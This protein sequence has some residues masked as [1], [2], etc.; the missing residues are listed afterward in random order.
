MTTSLAL[1]SI[2]AGMALLAAGGESLVRGAV[3][4]ARLLRV[5]TVVIGLTIVAMGTSAPELAASLTAALHGRGNIAVGNV[6]GSNIFN[7]ALIVGA[8][9]VVRPIAVHLSAVQ[10]EWP[11]MLTLSVA[12]VAM[13]WDGTV[14]RFEG[15]ALV[16]TLILFSVFLIVRA[17]GRTAPDEEQL[18][19][20]AVDAR[21]VRRARQRAVLDVGLVVL[22][23]LL[24]VGGAQLLIRGAVVVA[25]LLGLSDRVIGLTIVAAG[26]SMPEM[27]TSLVAARRGEAE[28]ALANVIGSNIF[29]I[30]G[31]L[32]T[33]ALVTPQHVPQATLSV[34]LWWMLGYTVVLLPLMRTGMRISRLEGAALLAGY[35]VY[36]A[37]LLG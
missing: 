33:V 15:A 31:I 25:E 7:I 6:V 19:T 5:G 21:T 32:G 36:L 23:M 24:L 18:L 10:I 16:L 12:A 9:A 20:A 4:L 13:T 8:A 30:T 27:A 14:G 2:V 37:L 26:T 28:I 1:L 34:D 3:S 22:G 11:V 35:G 29:N 17:R